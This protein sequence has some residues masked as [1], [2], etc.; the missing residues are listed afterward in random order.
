MEI[1]GY[2]ANKKSFGK[3]S[4]RILLI[5]ILGLLSLNV[6]TGQSYLIPVNAAGNKYP[7]TFTDEM[8]QT[9]IIEF[10]RAVTAAELLQAG[11]LLSGVQML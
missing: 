3:F 10:D 2:Q 7:I 1:E 6:V 5:F 4:T 11:Q 8:Q 9:L